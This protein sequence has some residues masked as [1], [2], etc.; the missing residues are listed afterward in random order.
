MNHAQCNISTL[1]VP[2]NKHLKTSSDVGF[3]AETPK[4]IY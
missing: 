4:E 1:S 3:I 2:G